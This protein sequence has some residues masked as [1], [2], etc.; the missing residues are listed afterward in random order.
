MRRCDMVLQSDYWLSPRSKIGGTPTS[1]S[2]ESTWN[3]TTNI[4]RW[5]VESWSVLFG[6]HLHKA[7]IAA[8]FASQFMTAPRWHLHMRLRVSED[9]DQLSVGVSDEEP[10]H[11]PRLVD[12]PMFNGKAC[13]SH[14]PVRLV[15]VIH[16]N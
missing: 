4:E 12:W 14:T 10:A 5:S 3:K 6:R 9:V 15:H 13:I 8:C 1:V 2:M 7:E 16:F 11:A